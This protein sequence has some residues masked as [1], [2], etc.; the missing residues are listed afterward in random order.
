MQEL[1]AGSGPSHPILKDVDPWLKVAAD[2]IRRAQSEGKVDAAVD[3]EAWLFNTGTLI[4][5]TLSL[6]DSSRTGGPPDPD[7]IVR[8]MARV[9]GTSLLGHTR[10]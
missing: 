7:R 9:I 2:L 6:L 5:S 1:L 3:P 4:L 10:S 8:E